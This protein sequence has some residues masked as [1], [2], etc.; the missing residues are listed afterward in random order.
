VGGAESEQ[1]R[2]TAPLKVAAAA[3]GLAGELQE[4][5]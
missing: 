5:E 4:Y 1:G 2:R 3:A